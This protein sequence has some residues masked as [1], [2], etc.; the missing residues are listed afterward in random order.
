M[1]QPTRGETVVLRRT[2]NTRLESLVSL[3]RNITLATQP[4]QFTLSSHTSILLGET[5]NISRSEEASWMRRAVARRGQETRTERML[6]HFLSVCVTNYEYLL[7]KVIF[8]TFLSCVLHIHAKEHPYPQQV[9]LMKSIISTI[10]ERRV[11]LFESPT[12]TINLFLF[13]FVLC[14]PL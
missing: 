11:G 9:D 3:L 10:Q 6:F 4:P 8:H 5:Q 7:V 1:F 12:G 2:K 13:C 14:T